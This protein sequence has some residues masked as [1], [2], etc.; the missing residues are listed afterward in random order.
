[1]IRPCACFLSYVERTRHS[2][3]HDDLL[4][5]DFDD[6]SPTHSLR[7]SPVPLSRGLKYSRYMYIVYIYILYCIH[8]YIGTTN[9]IIKGAGAGTAGTVAVGSMLM[10]IIKYS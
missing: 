8:M 4:N 9:Y 7:S 10:L 5:G 2:V 1:M 3:Q 6:Y